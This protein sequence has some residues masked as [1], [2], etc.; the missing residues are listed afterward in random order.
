MRLSESG[1]PCISTSCLYTRLTYHRAAITKFHLV[2]TATNNFLKPISKIILSNLV[3]TSEK[4]LSLSVLQR[5]HCRAPS[6]THLRW[7]RSVQSC[8]GSPGIRSEPR[9]SACLRSWVWSWSGRT[10]APRHRTRWSNRWRYGRCAPRSV[11]T[12]RR[13]GRSFANWW[14]RER[15]CNISI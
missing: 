9:R 7:H 13:N 3:M 1:Q 4:V 11:N 14:I 10:A 5:W 2:V 15:S 12:R 6:P 8:G